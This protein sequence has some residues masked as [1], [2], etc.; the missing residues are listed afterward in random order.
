MF[1]PRGIRPEGR[2]PLGRLRAAGGRSRGSAGDAYAR[3]VG[4]DLAVL[5]RR[6]GLDVAGDLAAALDLDLAVA[7][8]AGDPP[9]RLDQ[10]ALADHQVA[11]ETA[12]DL[13]VLDR[14]GAFEQPRFGDLDVAAVVEVGLDAALDD[15][16]VAGRDLARK[17]DLAA[18]GQLADLAVGGAPDRR[19]AGAANRLRRANRHRFA[20]ARQIG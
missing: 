4:E 20:G 1:R 3:H 12:L 6:L 18:D 13:G 8:R 15:Q 2:L 16:L 7:D 9:A 10:E 19:V 17:G 14:G 5:G 11:F